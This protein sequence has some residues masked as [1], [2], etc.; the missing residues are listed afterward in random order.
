MAIDS[1]AVIDYEALPEHANKPLVSPIFGSGMVL[2]RHKNTMLWGWA[3]PD[4][5]VTLKINEDVVTAQ[6]GPNCRSKHR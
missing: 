4:T 6:V 1:E 3:E 2:Q 5:I